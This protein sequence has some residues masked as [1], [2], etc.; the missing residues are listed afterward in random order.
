[1]VLNCGSKDISAL[2]L[3]HGSCFKEAW[4]AETFEQLLTSP[5][6][7]ALLA[8]HETADIGF[9]L[10]RVA[11]DE[12]EILS[13]GVTITARRQGIAG[14]ILVAAATRAAEAGATKMFLEVGTE[15]MPAQALYRKL[16]FHEVGRR[17]GYYRDG[18]GDGLT[19]RVDLP[20]ARLGNGTDLD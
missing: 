4:S 9:V 18:S 19:M 7:F 8:R 11:A 10:A 20:L 14:R 5:G 12:A 13:V 16:G 6:A 2:A 3:L 15:N 17:R 1:M